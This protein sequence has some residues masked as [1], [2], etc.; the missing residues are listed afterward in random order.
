[1]LIYLQSTS[2]QGDDAIQTTP[3]DLLYMSI[4]TNISQDLIRLK[5]H[6]IG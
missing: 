4:E 1:M 3:K 6:L 5:R 2:Q